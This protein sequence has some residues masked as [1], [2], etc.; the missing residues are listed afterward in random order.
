MAESV[1]TLEDEGGKLAVRLERNPSR[2]A[3]CYTAPDQQF[4]IDAA[5]SVSVGTQ[6]MTAGTFMALMDTHIANASPPDTIGRLLAWGVRQLGVQIAGI[7]DA[8]LHVPYS[9]WCARALRW[10]RSTIDIDTW[11]GAIMHAAYVVGVTIA[12]GGERCE[13]ELTED[14]KFFTSGSSDIPLPPEQCDHRHPFAISLDWWILQT[15]CRVNVSDML[16]ACDLWRGAHPSLTKWCKTHQVGLITFGPKETKVEARPRCNHMTIRI[17]NGEGMDHPDATVTIGRTLA[18][19]A[20]VRA[21]HVVNTF[22]ATE[23]CISLRNPWSADDMVGW[24][25][26]IYGWILERMSGQSIECLVNEAQ[27]PNG[28]ALGTSMSHIGA[29]YL[30]DA[31]CES[32]ARATREPEW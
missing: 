19:L 18:R 10:N 22:I 1:I 7:F 32:M 21:D 5:L 26:A 16:R 31:L 24:F 25:A 15:E 30:F 3:T 29:M 6:Y 9:M 12:G 17:C 13:I 8:N 2:G 20:F 4:F 14:F 23:Q 27:C 11:M 28:G